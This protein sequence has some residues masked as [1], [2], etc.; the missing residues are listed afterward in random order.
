MCTVTDL[1]SQHNSSPL[2]SVTA[3]PVYRSP[4]GLSL[5]WHLN[6]LFLLEVYYTLQKPLWGEDD[7]F[8]LEIN[9]AVHC[10]CQTMALRARADQ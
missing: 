8:G 6:C 3:T 1:P 5:A 2:L 9:G 4:H 10:G 7:E